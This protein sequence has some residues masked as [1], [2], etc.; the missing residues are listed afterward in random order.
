[1]PCPS[2]NQLA[3]FA[4]GLLSK[5]EA[6]AVASHVDECDPCRSAVADVARSRSSLSISTA[7]GSIEAPDRGSVDFPGQSEFGGGRYELL[8]LVGAGGM[9][10]VYEAWDSRLDR[11]VALKVML[12]ENADAERRL[13][14]EAR[15]MARLSHPNVVAIYDVGVCRGRTFIITELVV[16]GTLRAWATERAP[17]MREL[18][19]KLIDAS[20]GVEAAHAHGLLHL[21][22][23][24]NNILVDT[25]GRAK[26][27]DF[28]LAQLIH[29][30]GD[31]RAGTPAYAPPEIALDGAPQAAS[32]Q[33]GLC[34]TARS[35]LIH[36]S[37]WEALPRRLRTV[38]ERGLRD[39][40]KARYPSMSVLR[41]ALERTQRDRRWTAALGVAAVGIAALGFRPRV[42]TTLACPE[43]ALTATSTGVAAIDTA[44]RG[45]VERWQRAWESSCNANDDSHARQVRACLR[46]QRAALLEL[47]RVDSNALRDNAKEILAYLETH[48]D[49]AACPGPIEELP[50]LEGEAAQAL[51]EDLAAEGAR[52]PVDA[53]KVRVERLDRLLSRAH[54]QGDEM[55]VAD[56]LE[57]RGRAWIDARDFDAAAQDFEHASRLAY[58][59]GRDQTAVRA[60]LGLAL[61]HGVGRTDPATAE[62]LLPFIDAGL[63]RLGHPPKLEA[64][65]DRTL[66]SIYAYAGDAARAKPL[67][68]R[69][70]EQMKSV[71]GPDSIS[72]GTAREL[73]GVQAAYGRDFD[74]GREAL[75]EARAI[76]EAHFGPRARIVARSAGN[77][78][79]LEIAAG[80]PEVAAKRAAEAVDILVDQVSPDD[81]SLAGYRG[82]LATALVSAGRTEEG[83]SNFELVL[84]SFESAVAPGDPRMVNARYQVAWASS[85][86]GLARDESDPERKRQ[87]DAAEAQ[88]R[89]T[90]PYV[91][92]V[93]S[94]LHARIRLELGELA[95]L[96]DD[97]EEAISQC[98]QSAAVWTKPSGRGADACIA[99]AS[100]AATGNGDA[101]SPT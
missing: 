43:P 21:D 99:D 10:I 64:A 50:A 63:E 14:R 39:D 58:R 53:A 79:A 17:S 70:A 45:L 41:E 24:P 55:L 28:G 93:P 49:P 3:A 46:V 57:T 68:S 34:A 61:V 77:L 100:A 101:T 33:F 35:L 69:V 71:H 65:R 81:L 82:A 86:A 15:A 31:H 73:W 74:R 13:R 60:W 19:T 26:V 54:S 48:L 23:T 25:R 32:D 56:I 44:R 40:P 59:L 66:G 67:L 84:E 7:S 91:D 37:N 85:L 51:R 30:A 38:L 22:V 9:G 1:M 75:G 83:L 2:D 6:S 76:Y 5:R 80:R 92:H 47:D 27:C 96:R 20:R 42:A 11:S 16:G 18:L 72:Y 78:A 90:L 4:D 98:R 97:P 89:A 12:T 29:T 52:A 87:L 8:R 36:N 62:A 94:E 88:L 95:L